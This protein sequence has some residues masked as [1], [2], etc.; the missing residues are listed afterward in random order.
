MSGGSGEDTFVYGSGSDV[1]TDLEIGLDTVLFVNL[2]RGGIAVESQAQWEKFLHDRNAI[3]D[4]DDVLISFNAN[5]S[6]RLVGIAD[7]VLFA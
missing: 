1:I 2:K 4:G 3:V 6:L 5:D 7:N